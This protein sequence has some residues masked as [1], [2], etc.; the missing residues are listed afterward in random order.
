M[1]DTRPD[2]A[3]QCEQQLSALRQE[4]HQFVWTTAHE[5]RNPV[6]TVL[7]L[8]EILEGDEPPESLTQALMRMRR[9]AARLAEVVDDLYFRAELAAGN[10][11]VECQ[12]FG[13]EDLLADV[14]HT[15]EHMYPGQLLLEYGQLP[16]VV[17]DADHVRKI[18]VNLLLN[19]MR[20]SDA[21]MDDHLVRL[22]AAVELAPRRVEIRV[23]DLARLVPSEFCEAVFEPMAELPRELGHPRFG[24]GLGLYVGRLIT[25]QMGGD[26]WLDAADAASGGNVFA[27]SL[28]CAPAA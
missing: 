16:V 9:D 26:L 22:V 10:L 11:R 15:I 1:T 23:H 27:L 8:S 28:P 19:A 17:G 12:P 7:G 20:F 6:Q 21:V 13:L 2:T 24:L 18:L 3:A 25:R 5:L 14:A 4:F